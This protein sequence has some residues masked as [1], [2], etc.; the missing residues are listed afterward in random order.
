MNK[1][2]RVMIIDALNLFIRNFIV[3]PSIGTNGNPVGGV[4]GSLK[5]IQKLTRQIKPDEIVVVWDGPGGSRKKKS[6]LK[7]YKDGRKPIRLNR[8]IE[9]MTEDQESNNKVWQQFRL[10]EYLNQMPIIQI[11][12]DQIEA[13]D[14]IAFITKCDKY[15]NWNKIIVSSDK[16]FL[17][18]CDDKT[19]LYRPIQDKIETVVSVVSEFQIHPNNFALSRSIAGDKSDN[20]DGIGGAGLKSVAKYLP[21]L[22]ESKSYLISDIE[23]FCQEKILEKAK[24]KFY[25]SVINNL[26]K[27]KINYSLM[28]LYSP[29]ISVQVSQKMR[30]VTDNFV[31]EMNLTHFQK[32][33]VEDG[34]SEIN[35]LEMYAMM[36]RIVRDH[37]QEKNEN[38]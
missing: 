8:N 15:K 11:L 28:Q 33:T 9:N 20:I 27:I 4:K 10:F 16:D 12:E 6:I 25:Q 32:M 19:L 1:Q 13:D 7:E 34:F 24:V 18:L 37:N 23:I 2:K 30:Y 36:R 26:D 3:D 21:F 35:L 38:A 5:S 14:L 31:P 22:V 29:N 17:Q